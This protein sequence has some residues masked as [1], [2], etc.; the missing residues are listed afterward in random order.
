MNI[1][2]TIPEVILLFIVVVSSL[3]A[4]FVLGV[5]IGMNDK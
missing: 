2:L 3:L 1:V 5:W 4:V